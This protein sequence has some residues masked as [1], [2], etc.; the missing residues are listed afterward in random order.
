MCIKSTREACKAQLR[1]DTPT[2]VMQYT[3]STNQEDI[4]ST[5]PFYVELEGLELHR[6]LKW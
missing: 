5:C 1:A 4:V 3:S 6:N 2:E